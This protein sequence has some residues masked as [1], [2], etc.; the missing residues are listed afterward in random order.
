[1][2]FGEILGQHRGVASLTSAVASGR[3]PGGYL[4][5][6]PPGV[7]KR[8][9]AIELTKA[10][11][12]LS[13][14]DGCGTCLH[15]RLIHQG[16]FPD[17]HVPVPRSG[18]ITKGSASDKEPSGLAPI[19]PRLHYRPV[20]GRMKVAILDPADGLTDEAGNMLLKVLEEPPPATLFILVTTLEHA[21]LPTLVSRCQRI[22][23][24]P[25]G[26]EPIMTILQTRGVDEH[27]ACQ[28]ARVC[29][30]SPGTAMALVRAGD[31]DQR[32]EAA[33][34]LWTLFESPLSARV[35]AAVAY[36]GAKQARSKV[37]AD[38]KTSPRS[39][40]GDVGQT[41]G[42]GE[43][44]AAA[45]ALPLPLLSGVGAMVAR[46]LL[47]VACGGS[48]AECISTD[49]SDE[50]ARLAGRLGVSGVLRFSSVMRGLRQAIARNE[51]PR[52]VVL[53]LGNKLRSLVV[54]TAA[55][56]P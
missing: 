43:A 10:L 45:T 18:R 35:E 26:I 9:T 28:A 53:D 15:C 23:F 37:G 40:K 6:G 48:R 42:G 1:M 3:L 39:K 24:A 51:A 32:G 34:F 7:G 8:T 19:L 12:C 5:V 50:I 46:D 20:M 56:Q 25:L 52:T 38:R 2:A 36:L 44:G 27:T 31:L 21:V 41:E 33:R 30:G 16:E 17:L 47:W 13:G 4:F 11:N 54:D 29:M 55:E 14:T 49:M 22:R